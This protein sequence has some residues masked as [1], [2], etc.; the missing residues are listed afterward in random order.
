MN[1]FGMFVLADT[2]LCHVVDTWLCQDRLF[3]YVDLCP[4]YVDLYTL[5]DSCFSI[6]FETGKY[7]S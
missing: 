7:E 1:G 6:N 4:S 2:W 3:D 5:N